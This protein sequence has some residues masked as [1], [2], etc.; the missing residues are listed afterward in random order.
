MCSITHIYIYIYILLC[1]WYAFAKQSGHPADMLGGT[2][3][4][5]LGKFFYA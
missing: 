1:P 2:I 5:I 4:F 3:H